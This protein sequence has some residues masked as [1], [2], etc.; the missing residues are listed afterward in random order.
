MVKDYD[1]HNCNKF[2]NK[3]HLAKFQ[4]YQQID[5]YHQQKTGIFHFKTCTFSPLGKA[6]AVENSINNYKDVQITRSSTRHHLDFT[7]ERN[8]KEL[9]NTCKIMIQNGDSYILHKR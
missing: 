1:T 2:L 5:K 8:K 6:S 3:N 9:E 7:I 4:Q